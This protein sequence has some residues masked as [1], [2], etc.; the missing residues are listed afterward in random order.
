MS[1]TKKAKMPSE[2]QAKALA[3]LFGEIIIFSFMVKGRADTLPWNPPTQIV[4]VK[5]KWAA[6]DGETYERNGHVFQNYKIS[7]AGLDALEYYLFEQRCKR[8]T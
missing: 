2:A 3:G 6:P 1:R 8:K 4:L 5:Q 7:E